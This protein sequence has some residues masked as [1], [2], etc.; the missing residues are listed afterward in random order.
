[1]DMYVH[2]DSIYMYINKPSL[3]TIR[4]IIILLNYMEPSSVVNA[5][6]S[7]KQKAEAG[8]SL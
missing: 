3:E 5:F 6:N 8:G 4:K 2:K 1:M 7:S